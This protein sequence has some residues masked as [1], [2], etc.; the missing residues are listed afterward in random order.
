M[1]FPHINKL[2]ISIPWFDAYPNYSEIHTNLQ[3]NQKNTSTRTESHFEKVS[4]FIII[5]V[6]LPSFSVFFFLSN[7][8]KKKIHS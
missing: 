7:K 8:K 5:I 1:S 3:E 4:F 6:C 2:T